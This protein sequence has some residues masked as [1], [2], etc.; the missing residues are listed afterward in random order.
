MDQRPFLSYGNFS[1][2]LCWYD[3]QQHN[4]QQ[5]NS[6]NTLLWYWK[7]STNVNVF[8]IRRRMLKHIGHSVVYTRTQQGAGNKK[9]LESQKR[10][11][12]QAA[13]IEKT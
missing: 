2:F 10:C 9:R 6:V 5:W 3:E 8:A 1:I 11:V 7:Q 12:Q 4:K 13:S